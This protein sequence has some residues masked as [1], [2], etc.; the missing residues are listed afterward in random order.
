MKQKIILFCILVGA[1]FAF[2]AAGERK[3]SEAVDIEQSVRAFLT[4]YAESWSSGDMKTYASLFHP[5][6]MVAY[7]EE[8]K[9]M[10]YRN[11]RAFI[12]VQ[13]A[14][15]SGHPQKKETFTGMKIH[16]DEKAASVE[17][18]Y[19]LESREKIVFGIDRFTLY[20]AAGGDWRIAS[21]VFY[22]T[23]TVEKPARKK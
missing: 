11:L 15:Q 21:L 13:R 14:I 22:R 7:V 12:A 6:A 9:L 2:G 3:K 16:A 23:K 20:R 18:Q 5:A 19:R 10:P 8:D 4:R 17:A 1:L